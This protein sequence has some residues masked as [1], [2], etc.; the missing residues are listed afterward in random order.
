MLPDFISY[1][2]QVIEIL[3]QNSQGGRITYKAIEIATNK[4]IIIKQFT[5]AKTSD[6]DGYKEI[7]RE[8]NVLQGLNHDGIPKFLKTF[9]PDN[10]LC[11]VLESI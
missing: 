8:I 11:L 10:G 2:Y 9:D 1:G 7:E 5:F 6:W 4:P 3:Q